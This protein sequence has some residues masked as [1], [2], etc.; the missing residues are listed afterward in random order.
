MKC[1]HL[2]AHG[3][4]FFFSNLVTRPNDE[5]YLSILSISEVAP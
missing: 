5:V 2:V 4:Q 1:R 3:T